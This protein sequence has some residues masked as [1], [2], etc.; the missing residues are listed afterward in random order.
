M[1]RHLQT[2]ASG[3]LR[4]QTKTFE[5]LGAAW[6]DHEWSQEL[7]APGA[8]C[9]NWIA[10]NLIDGSALTAFRL[11]GKDGDT[12]RDGGSFRSAA[13]KPGGSLYVFNRGEVIFTATRFWKSPAI[14]TTYPVGWIVRTP[15]DSY[16][17]KAVIDNQELDRRQSI[18]AI[19]WE[20]LSELEDSNGKKVGMGYLEMT[21]YSQPLRM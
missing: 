21:G 6:L 20:G 10:M 19:Y 8:V 5:V 13:S 2:S 4:V 16:T 9:W 11:R 3:P 14:Q 15:A 17:V 1:T 7:L 18:G 12:I